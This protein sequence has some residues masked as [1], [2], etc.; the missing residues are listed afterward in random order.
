MPQSILSTKGQMI[1]PKEIREALH[2]KRGTRLSLEL[3]GS[4]IIVEVIP[5]TRSDPIAFWRGCLRG[6]DVLEAHCA[7]HAMEVSRE[8]LP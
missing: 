5:G 8:R 2:L 3:E 4:R 6:T 7:E 1:I